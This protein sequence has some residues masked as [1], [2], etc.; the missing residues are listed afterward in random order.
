MESSSENFRRV[1]LTY[2]GQG[3]S[4]TNLNNTDRAKL[5]T[6]NISGF[7]YPTEHFTILRIFKLASNS[8]PVF[9]C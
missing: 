6:R 9:Y 3:K 2:A 5:A 7:H 8:E 1:S 4:Q